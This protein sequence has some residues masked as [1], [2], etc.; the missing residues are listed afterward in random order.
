MSRNE[1][2]NGSKGQV[3]LAQDRTNLAEDRTNMAHERTELARERN[4]LAKERNHL[5]NERTFQAW[6]RT[7][8]SLMALGFVIEQFT[9]FIRQS[10]AF[11]EDKIPEQGDYTWIIGKLLIVGAIFML[12]IAY[13]RYHFI[14]RK[15][16]H[17]KHFPSKWL[18]TLVVLC[19]V[20]G[21]ALIVYDL[22]L[23]I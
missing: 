11:L 22:V 6:I 10:S 21:V 8:L 2:S 13:F 7:S 17:S 16:G 4:E 15:I 12:V 5:A 9:L 20:V 3:D 1:E 19:I 14:A 23:K 18:S